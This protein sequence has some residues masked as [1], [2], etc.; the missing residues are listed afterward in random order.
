M[1]LLHGNRPVQDIEAR[2]TEMEE[3]SDHVRA[4]TAEG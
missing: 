1:T 4:Y 3:E 2:A